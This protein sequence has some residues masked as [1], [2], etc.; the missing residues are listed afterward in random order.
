MQKAAKASPLDTLQE[1]EEE[2]VKTRR[3][4]LRRGEKSKE[5][6]VKEA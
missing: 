2:W 1:L 4:S 5:P 3:N 6:G